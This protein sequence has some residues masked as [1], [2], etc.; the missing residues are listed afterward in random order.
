MNHAGGCR[1][2]FHGLFHGTEK[3]INDFAAP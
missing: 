1:E 3:W 2:L